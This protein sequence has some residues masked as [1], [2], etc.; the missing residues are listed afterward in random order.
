MPYEAVLIFA[1]KTF[2]LDFCLG[3]KCCNDKMHENSI[4]FRDF[5]GTVDSELRQVLKYES[6][7]VE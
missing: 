2:G 7:S 6:L 3:Q 5:K 1:F 4:I